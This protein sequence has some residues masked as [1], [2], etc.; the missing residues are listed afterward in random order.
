MLCFNW[1]WVVY[2]V[3]FDIEGLPILALYLW[4]YYFASQVLSWRPRALY[5]PN[6]ATAEQCKTIVDMAKSHLKPSLLALRKGE[7]DESTKGTRTRY[8]Y[9]FFQSVLYIL[10]FLSS[11]ALLCS[12]YIIFCDNSSGTF[13]SASEDDTGTLEFIEKKIAQATMIPRSHGEVFSANITMCFGLKLEEVF[14]LWLQIFVLEKF[15]KCT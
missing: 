13:I 12:W 4:F 8:Y 14:V 3:L 10:Q 6:F 15:C 5:F 11:A 9:S 2:H 1:V 7:T